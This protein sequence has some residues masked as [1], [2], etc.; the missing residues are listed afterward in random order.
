MRAGPRSPCHRRAIGPGEYR[1]LTV[2]HGQPDSQVRPL[3]RRAAQIPKLIVQAEEIGRSACGRKVQESWLGS[4]P[5]M[6][7]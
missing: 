5:G 3:E 7:R 1:S 2:T 4:D 6:A